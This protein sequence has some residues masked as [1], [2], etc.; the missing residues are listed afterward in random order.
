MKIIT[1]AMVALLATAS[2][3][4]ATD[5]PKKKTAPAAPAPVAATTAAPADS[6]TIQYSYDSDPLN[7]SG[8]KQQDNQ[9][10]INY[11]HQ[12]GAGFAIGAKA[13]MADTAN[14]DNVFKGNA[15]LNGYYAMP[16]GGGFIAKA[17]LGLGE[18]QNSG[19][20]AFPYYAVYGGAD[21]KVNDTWT[22]NA[23]NYRYRNAFDT[24]NNFESHQ[25][26]TA[27][28][29]NIDTYNAVQ[30]GV[31]RTFDNGWNATQD[32]LFVAYTRKF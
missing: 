23:I 31:Q 13:S 8:A 1:T 32:T 22:I 12:L 28:T 9:A 25:L 17:A 24:S 29:Y 7:N 16:I 2:V 14:G 20:A 4:F 5:L 15:E 6:I 27:V 11:V 21:Y 19:S 3:A 30:G 18:K 26:T 10:Q